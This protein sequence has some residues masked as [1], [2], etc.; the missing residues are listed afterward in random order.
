MNF[1]HMMAYVCG[2]VQHLFDV[3]NCTFLLYLSR[4]QLFEGIVEESVTVSS[5]K[6]YH[7]RSGLQLRSESDEKGNYIF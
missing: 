6:H 4:V 2:N 5:G 3:I 7:S 1:M